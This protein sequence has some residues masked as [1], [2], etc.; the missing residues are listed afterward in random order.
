MCVFVALVTQHSMR[1]DHI[2]IRGLYGGTKLLSHYLKNCTIFAKKIL[3][4]ECVLIFTTN[5]V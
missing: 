1:M 4:T 2:A 3:N 5:F